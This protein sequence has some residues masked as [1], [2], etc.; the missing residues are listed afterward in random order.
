MKKILIILLSTIL[1]AGCTS[2]VSQE[3]YDKLLEE[4][5]TLKEKL[6][7]YEPQAD[8]NNS[9]TSSENNQQTDIKIT[10]DGNSIN[11]IGNDESIATI[12]NVSVVKS[13]QFGYLLIIDFD[14]TNKS[15]NAKNFINDS[16]CR[17]KPFQN[18]IELD[19]PG[20]TSEEGTYNYTEAHTRI[21]NGA[22]IHTQLVWK[23][24]DIKNP[25][26]IEFGINEN[27]EPAYIRKLKFS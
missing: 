25:I 17:V 23:L 10:W 7:V 13:Q 15:K 1:L 16:Y 27:Y 12:K 6:A 2:G 4:N 11:K 21:K 8:K 14:Y 22:I 20:I 3:E 18:G 19:Y 5:K 9:D 26:E 24:L